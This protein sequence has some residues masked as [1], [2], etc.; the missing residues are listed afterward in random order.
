MCENPERG[1]EKGR[2]RK[3]L[4]D[5]GGDLVFRARALVE[6]PER[7][8][9]VSAYAQWEASTGYGILS[10]FIICPL[11]RPLTTNTPDFLDTLYN[12]IQILSTKWSRDQAVLPG[13][14]TSRGLHNASLTAR[15]CRI[16]L[17]QSIPKRPMTLLLI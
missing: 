15:F 8:R 2:K 9:T 10:R 5:Q 6:P 14:M 4:T 1:R 17:K 7:Q 11:F 12:Y 16:R 13:K 3:K